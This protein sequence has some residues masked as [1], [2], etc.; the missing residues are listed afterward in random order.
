MGQSKRLLH[1][2]HGV[3]FRII[4]Q[5]AGDCFVPVLPEKI[6]VPIERL[7][8]QPVGAFSLCLLLKCT[9]KR[10]TDSLPAA[11]FVHPKSVDFR[12]VPAIHAPYDPGDEFPILVDR[13]FANG[14]IDLLTFFM[15]LM[16]VSRLLSM[17][18]STYFVRLQW[19]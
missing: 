5:H 7:N 4:L 2:V 18:V 14:D 9:E 1:A 6:D 12:V 17:P 10:G 19:C 16:L 15:F 11:G 13:L 3:P 8:S